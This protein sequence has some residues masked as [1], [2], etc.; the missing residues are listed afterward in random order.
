MSEDKQTIETTSIEK[1]EAQIDEA[2]YNLF[3]LTDKERETI[4]EYLEIF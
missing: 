3:E 4:E 2:V 1:L